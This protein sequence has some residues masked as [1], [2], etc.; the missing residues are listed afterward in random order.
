MSKF[1]CFSV[2]LLGSQH[3]RIPVLTHNRRGQLVSDR[4]SAEQLLQAIEAGRGT[5]AHVGHS[6]SAGA[7]TWLALQ[8][9][10]RYG[11][12]LVAMQAFLAVRK[13]PVSTLLFFSSRRSL[14]FACGVYRLSCLIFRGS[15]T[16]QEEA[17]RQR[18]IKE[19]RLARVD[20]ERHVKANCPCAT[21]C[22][23]RD[24]AWERQVDSVRSTLAA[25]RAADLHV[26]DDFVR[27]GAG[28]LTNVC[29]LHR[30]CCISQVT[31]KQFYANKL[32]GMTQWEAP[33]L[34]PPKKS[35][36]PEWLRAGSKGVADRHIAAITTSPPAATAV[37]PSN[38]PD[39]ARAGEAECDSLRGAKTNQIS[40]HKA[41]KGKP[42]PHRSMAAGNSAAG[43]SPGF[44][45][46]GLNWYGV[47]QKHGRLT[48]GAAK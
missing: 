2:R 39:E 3:E 26:K 44:A 46:A 20:A 27:R 24:L 35:G 29:I 8:K 19:A 41:V 6:V 45:S 23:L 12:A 34:P 43:I 48:I 47:F 36:I 42:G 11:T 32:S 15:P 1:R 17:G 18:K 5:E 7:D 14:Q 31:G 30:A 25:S 38:N 28:T 16:Q 9:R 13:P 37:Q 33:S 4:Q 10:R 22:E 40:K 21:C